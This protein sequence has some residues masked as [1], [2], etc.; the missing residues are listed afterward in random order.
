MDDLIFVVITLSSIA[1]PALAAVPLDEP[2]EPEVS[3]LPEEVPDDVPVS[4]EPEAR[5]AVVVSVAP[6]PEDACPSVGWR[7][8][9][10]VVATAASMSATST[11]CEV[12][13]NVFM[14]LHPFH[15][16]GAGLPAWRTSSRSR[17]VKMES[18][19]QRR[20]CRRE[21][22]Y[23]VVPDDEPLVEPEVLGVE[24]LGVDEVEPLGVVVVEEPV[25]A[26]PDVAP[27][28]LVL[29]LLLEPGVVVALPVPDVPVPSEPEV[30]ADVLPVLP[31]VPVEP[32]VLGVVPLLVPA[33]P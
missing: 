6:T 16:N 22:G 31:V 1:T 32:A 5:E 11:A 20:C 21:I 10:P 18:R 29:E 23:L 3:E 17:H 9:H 24:L 15:S 26:L 27:E 33:A 19:R 30:P 7:R 2:E 13:D 25:P 28:G 14:C 8:V 12:L 4:D